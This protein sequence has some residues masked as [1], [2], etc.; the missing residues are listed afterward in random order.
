MSPHLRRVERRARRR[1]HRRAGAA[2]GG[3]DSDRV[4]RR[5][6]GPG[7]I[8]RV[9]DRVQRPFVGIVDCTRTWTRARIEFDFERL[10]V[11]AKGIAVLWAARERRGVAADA[12]RRV[13]CSHVTRA[14]VRSWRRRARRAAATRGAALAPPATSAIALDQALTLVYRILFLL[15]AEARGMVPIWHELYR[16]AY[17]V[18]VLARKAAIR[19]TRADCGRRCRRSRGWRT[20]DA[21][22]PTSRSRRSTAAC[23]RR[24]MRRLSS[25]DAGTDDGGP[26]RAAVAGHREHAQDAAASRITTSAS[27]N[28]DRS[29]SACSSMSRSP[30]RRSFAHVDRAQD[31]RQLLHAA[32]DH[33]VPGQAHARAAGRTEARRRNPRVA[34]PRS[35]DGQR[36]VSGCGLP[37]SGRQCERAYI[38]EG[39]WPAG[40][41][42]AA[43]R[44]TLTRQIAS[45]ACSAS[46]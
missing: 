25:S 5:R 2:V 40:E 3:A 18:D 15:F 44:A 34:H 26:G 30:G 33:R 22:P 11:T 35:G 20:R 32:L 9:G 27:S 16:D 41:V 13:G 1:R 7:R 45:D 21:R 24:G 43:D 6:R 8:G 38:D 14:R 29:T 36:R 42:R 12:R 17:S 39:Q 28:S 37:L 31:D 23:S 46:I 10:L 4:A 19:G